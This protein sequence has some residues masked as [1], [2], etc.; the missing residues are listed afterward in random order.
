[1]SKAKKEAAATA[2]ATDTPGKT[3]TAAINGTAQ[4]VS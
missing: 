4:M 2:A 3:T 1:M